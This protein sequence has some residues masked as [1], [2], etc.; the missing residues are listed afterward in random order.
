[1]GVFICSFI[2]PHCSSMISAQVD[3]V[4]EGKTSEGDLGVQV[5]KCYVEE[6]ICYSIAE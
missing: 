5:P 1:M 2:A 4:K 3:V 6:S